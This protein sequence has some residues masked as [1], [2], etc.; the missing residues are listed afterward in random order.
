MIERARQ[1]IRRY[2]NNSGYGSFIS[3]ELC[4]ELAEAVIEEIRK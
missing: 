4:E 3:D 2:A 1:A